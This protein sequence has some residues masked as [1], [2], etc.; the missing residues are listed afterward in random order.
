VSVATLPMTQI[1]TQATR[2]PLPFDWGAL[3]PVVIHPLKVGIIEA[4]CWIGEP[5]SAID[6][7]R[8]FSDQCLSTSSLSY[9]VTELAK[10]GVLEQ[11]EAR[12]IRGATKKSF[13]FSSSE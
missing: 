4:L 3:V 11:V 6:F 9:H 1:S 10:A 13:F 2:E 7:K 12:Q 5:L 8:L